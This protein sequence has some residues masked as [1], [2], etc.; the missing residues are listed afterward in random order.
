VLI[1]Y[2]GTVLDPMFTRN[3]FWSSIQF[4][5]KYPGRRYV[6]ELSST[7]PL[8]LEKWE[9]SQDWGPL[10]A[11]IWGT[12]YRLIQF[13]TRGRVRLANDCVGVAEEA[14]GIAGIDVPIWVSTPIK[15]KRWMED[16]GYE[17]TPYTPPGDDTADD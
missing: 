9:Q 14:L 8:T 3:R 4:R 15:L 11:S 17:C 1:E 12:I 13:F 10:R 16:H 7:T 2:D 5:R 6:F